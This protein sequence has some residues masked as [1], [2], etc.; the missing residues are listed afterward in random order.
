MVNNWNCGLL[1]INSCVLLYG[2]WAL[3]PGLSLPYP[4]SRLM[5]PHTPRPAPRAITRVW[6]V[7]IADWKNAILYLPE[8]NIVPSPKN[9]GGF[10]SGNSFS[11]IAPPSPGSVSGVKVSVVLEIYMKSAATKLWLHLMRV[12]K[13][14]DRLQLPYKAGQLIFCREQAEVDW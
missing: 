7:V 6:R 1:S 10:C 3:A 9:G 11:R 2:T 13:V 14:P 4:S 5:P 8:Q 12:Y